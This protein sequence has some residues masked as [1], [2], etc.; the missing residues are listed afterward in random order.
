MKEINMA[1]D[2]PIYLRK[3]RLKRIRKLADGI[4]EA[5]LVSLESQEEDYVLMTP[6]EARQ[7]AE[8]IAKG[9]R[10]TWREISGYDV[11]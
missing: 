7:L 8:A 5:Y 9:A 2:E 4:V 6:Q 3:V 1:D 11:E 10:L